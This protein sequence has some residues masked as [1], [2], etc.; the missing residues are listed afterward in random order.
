VGPVGHIFVPPAFLLKLRF[1]LGNAG[2]DL[3]GRDGIGRRKI[4]RQRMGSK[5]IS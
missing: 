2:S 3:F 1:A 4:A 5:G